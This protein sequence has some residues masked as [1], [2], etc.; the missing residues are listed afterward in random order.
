MIRRNVSPVLKDTASPIYTQIFSRS[1]GAPIVPDTGYLTSPSA[2]RF[3]TK[4]ATT[5]KRARLLWR[6]HKTATC[7]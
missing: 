5:Y 6:G 7:A 4:N 2:A 1:P 3:A